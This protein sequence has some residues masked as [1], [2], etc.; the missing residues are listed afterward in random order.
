MNLSARAAIRHLKGQ[1]TCGI[2][3]PRARQDATSAPHHPTCGRTN[4]PTNRTSVNPSTHQN[5][6]PPNYRPANLR[7]GPTTVKEQRARLEP[8]AG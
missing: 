4:S 2:A 1:P 5:A 6:A 3:N 7:P 8:H